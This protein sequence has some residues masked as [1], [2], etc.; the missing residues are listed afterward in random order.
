[1]TTHKPTQAASRVKT[2]T[3]KA[4][5][6]TP[7]GTNGGERTEN[8]KVVP[9]DQWWAATAQRDAD[10]VAAKTTEYGSSGGDLVAVGRSVMEIGPSHTV[11]AGV[12]P[13]AYAAEV[14]VYFYALG[15]AA[16]I[17]EGYRAGHLASDETWSDLTTYSMMARRIRAAGQWGGKDLA[18]WYVDTARSDRAIVTPKTIEYGAQGDDLVMSGSSIA[19]INGIATPAKRSERGFHTELAIFL[20]I[21]G[22]LARLEEGYRAGR[23]PSDDT[24][25]D[26]TVYS[27]MARRAREVGYFG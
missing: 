24:W 20:Y 16:R 18:K 21:R 3:E 12:D 8:A 19:R 4:A 25:F 27:M 1:M 23:L 2:A 11:P 9:L 15:K 14:G 17:E 22:K 26:T 10:R 5:S 13:E 7:S 6:P